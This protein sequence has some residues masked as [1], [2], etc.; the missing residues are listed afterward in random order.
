MTAKDS[1][2]PS[3]DGKAALLR[4]SPQPRRGQLLPSSPCQSPLPA[5]SA[6]GGSG[7]RQGTDGRQEPRRGWPRCWRKGIAPGLPPLGSSRHF[8]LARNNYICHQRSPTPAR[9]LP[10]PVGLP[11]G[12]RGQEPKEESCGFFQAL[13][14]PR[15]LDA[16]RAMNTGTN[17]MPFTQLQLLFFFIFLYTQFQ[18][19]KKQKT[20]TYDITRQ[21]GS[22]E[23]KPFSFVLLQRADGSASQ[24]ISPAE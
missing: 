16:Q 2:S 9:I 23:G 18:I 8:P 3:G 7:G 20:Q 6:G 24:L 13:F 10:L 19:K 5:G 15:T 1:F 12:E 17:L 22:G 21:P 11:Q 4:A 14:N